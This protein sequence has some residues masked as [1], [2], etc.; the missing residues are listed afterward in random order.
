MNKI[1]TVVNVY[2]DKYD[3]YIG[4]RSEFGDTKWG[5]PFSDPSMDLAEKLKCY[6]DYIRKSPDL[7]NSLD[8]L[9][10]KR[11]GCHCKPKVCHGDILKKLV[12]EKFN[13]TERNIWQKWT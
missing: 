4:R 5:N 10:G 12:I 1:P 11:L 6:E 3:V 8:S 7:W 9:I 13:L 2:K